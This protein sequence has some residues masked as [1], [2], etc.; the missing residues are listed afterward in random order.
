ME[1]HHYY[2]CVHA[3][4]ES[5]VHEKWTEDLPEVADC[6][7]GVTVDLSQPVAGNVY[8]DGLRNTYYQVGSILYGQI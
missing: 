2:I 7:D 8:V 6:S 1:G 4:A 5:L 3:A